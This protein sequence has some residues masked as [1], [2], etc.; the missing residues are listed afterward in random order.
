MSNISLYPALN[1]I[2]VNEIVKTKYDFYFEDKYSKKYPLRQEQLDKKSIKV[3]DPNEDWVYRDNGLYI[4]IST[5]I[6]SCDRMFLNPEVACIDAQVGYGIEWYSQE[7]RQRGFV[8]IGECNKDTKDNNKQVELMLNYK[9]FKDNVNFDIVFFI[10]TPGSADDKHRHLANE[11]GIIIGSSRLFSLIL[12][13]SGSIFPVM[14]I[15]DAL[16]PLWEVKV[17]IESVE[18]DQFNKDYV[19]IYLNK[20]HKDYKYIDK[21]SKEFNISFLK[22][23][24]SSA[25]T[26]IISTL[27]EGCEDHSIDSNSEE[28]T[29]MRILYYFQEKHKFDYSSITNLSNSIKLYFDKEFKF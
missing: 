1:S 14:S 7:S 8:V 16:K 12:E 4:K 2:L 13:G 22:D 9:D 3:T 6:L 11:P 18:E 21:G 29:I 23:V 27:I 28:G 15:A 24:L 5:K 25:I 10:D 19:C 17:D 20:E 26:Q